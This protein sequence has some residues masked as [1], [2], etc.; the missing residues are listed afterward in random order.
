[1]RQLR[2]LFRSR[3]SP[4]CAALSGVAFRAFL[5]FFQAIRLGLDGD[6]L[7]AMY[8]PIDERNHAP[9]VGEHLRP[10]GKRLVG[11][12]EGALGLVASI[13]QLEEKIGVAVGVGQIADFVDSEEVRCGVTA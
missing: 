3:S 8:E 6:H 5:G 1:M 13:Q 10:G 2:A 4:A 11:G 7:G 9:G 12:D